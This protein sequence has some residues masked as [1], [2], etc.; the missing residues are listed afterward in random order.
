VISWRFYPHH[1]DIWL[2]YNGSITIAQELRADLHHALLIDYGSWNLFTHNSLITIYLLLNFF[3]RN[4]LYIDTLLFSFPVFMGTTAL[5]RVFR[6]HFPGSMLPAL[7]VYLLPSVLFWTGCIH[8]EAALFMFL[9]FLLYYMDR[10]AW[11][12][13]AL[14]LLLIAYFRS[15]VALP[16]LPALAAWWWLSLPAR[17]QR[18]KI[19]LAGG[20]GLLII[21]ILAAPLLLNGLAAEQQT[22]QILQGNSRINLPVLDGRFGNFLHTLPAA[23]LN[24]WLEPLPGA[25]GQLI[26]TAFSCELLLT[27]AVVILALIRRPTLSSFSIGCIVFA[28]LGM[29][30]VGLVV[31]FV[32]AIVRYRSIYLPFLLAPFLNSL[33]KSSHEL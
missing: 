32:G 33:S 21:L 6:R 7:S 9:G 26:Y 3:S 18:K 30:L 10:R 28:L 5:F 4:N 25:G 20:I 13:A 24:G 16:L 22:F 14:F 17:P 11:K 8:R 15:A 1:G 23:L 27:W 2:Y 12:T 19:L 31:P 29:L